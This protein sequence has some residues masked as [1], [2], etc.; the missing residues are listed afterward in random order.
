MHKS[1]TFT[2]VHPDGSRVVK[3]FGKDFHIILDDHSLIVGGNLNI[4]V[5]GNANLV[6]K[7]DL[8]QKIGGNLET[9][10][11]GNLTTRVSG[12]TTHYSKQDFQIE[13]DNNFKVLS[14]LKQQFMAKSSI[15]IQTRENFTLKANLVSRFWSTGRTYIR[16]SRVDFNLPTEVAPSTINIKSKDIGPGLIVPDS[17]TEPSIETQRVLK[18]GNNNLLDIVE[19]D[20]IYPKDRT[21]KDE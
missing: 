8:K 10:V 6:V 2:E 5:E 12:T 15:D 13:T 19:T 3:I 7:G 17:L 1:G 9:I 16:G 11:H 20:L 18:T 21:I 14:T 4:V